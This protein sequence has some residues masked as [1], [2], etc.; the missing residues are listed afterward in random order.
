MKDL[1]RS[2]IFESKVKHEH[3]INETDY[4]SQFVETS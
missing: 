4:K 1:L 2:P 3:W